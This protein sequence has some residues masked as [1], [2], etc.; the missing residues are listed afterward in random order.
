MIGNHESII[1][2]HYTDA[3]S[4]QSDALASEKYDTLTLLASNNILKSVAL[5]FTVS[6]NIFYCVF[7]YLNALFVQSLLLEYF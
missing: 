6:G 1:P 7:C 4:N 5:V 2:E 3:I